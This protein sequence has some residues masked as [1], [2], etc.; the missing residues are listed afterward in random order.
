MSSEGSFGLKILLMAA[1]NVAHS[2]G[3]IQTALGQ[4]PQES[5]P[6]AGYL[7]DNVTQ[8]SPRIDGSACI[9]SPTR[10]LTEF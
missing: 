5:V 4:V 2:D 6:A 8:C 10:V 1:S 9:V 7:C 3:D